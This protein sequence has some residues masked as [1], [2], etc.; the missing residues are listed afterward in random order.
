M[1]L[2]DPYAEWNPR[3]AKRT[4]LGIL[5]EADFWELPGPDRVHSACWRSWRRARQ[6]GDS[7]A[8][9]SMSILTPTPH[10]SSQSNCGPRRAWATYQK[11]HP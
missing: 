11:V 3:S 5:R 1:V 10:W 2:R 7:S 4:L 9:L 8:E 6:P